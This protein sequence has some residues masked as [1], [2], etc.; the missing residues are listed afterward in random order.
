MRR[1]FSLLVRSLLPA[2]FGFSGAF[3]ASLAWS[4]L[5]LEMVLC[6]ASHA[7]FSRLLL[8]S[9]RLVCKFKHPVV[10]PKIACDKTAKRKG[11]QRA[12]IPP[13]HLTDRNHRLP[14]RH[15]SSSNSYI[16]TT[17]YES[18][19]QTASPATPAKPRP[20]VRAPHQHVEVQSPGH[21]RQSQ[22]KRH[23]QTRRRSQA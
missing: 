5:S 11:P 3:D 7:Y 1:W 13:L 6:L 10:A 2:W 14:S 18:I 23:R 17:T 4:L 9:L 22:V 12:Y 21:Y 8:R 19:C 20:A 15:P 16:H